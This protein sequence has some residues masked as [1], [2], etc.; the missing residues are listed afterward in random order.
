[1]GTT[2]T[3]MLFSGGCALLVLIGDSCAFRLRGRQLRQITGHHT[4]DNLV[5]DAD[6]LV[7]VIARHLDRRPDRQA[8]MGLRDLRAGGR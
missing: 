5:W 7:P 3:A 2:L 6:L 1:M 8:G 4:I